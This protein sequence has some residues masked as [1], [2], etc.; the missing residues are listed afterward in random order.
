[1]SS[2]PRHALDPDGQEPSRQVTTPTRPTTAGHDDPERHLPE[3]HNPLPEL[4]GDIP[5]EIDPARL[6]QVQQSDDFRE[7]K[8]RFRSFA[9]PLSIAFLVWY[10]AFVLMSTYAV[11]FMSRPLFGRVSVGL[12]LGL[13][14][15]LTTFVI[16]ALYIRHANKNLDPIANRIRTELEGTR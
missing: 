9:F 10:F 13:L 16:T 4:T 6:L 15:F 5:G 1:M 7:L 3:H 8:R 11:D 12:V 2:T 14:Q